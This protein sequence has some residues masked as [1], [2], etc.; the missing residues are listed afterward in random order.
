MK[1]KIME[2]LKNKFNIALIT[3]QALA[4]ISY[5]LNMFSVFLF[6]FFMFEAAFLIVW[7][8]KYICINR[9]SKAQMAVYNELPY[10]DAQKEYLRKNCENNSKNNKI[11][12]IML[13]VLGVVLFFS[14]F[15]M[16][17]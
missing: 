9:T 10:T 14:G 17:F 6:F 5:C 1:Q 2:F 3:L 7:G 13:I 15:S 12:S 4:I 16:I 11:M 8:V